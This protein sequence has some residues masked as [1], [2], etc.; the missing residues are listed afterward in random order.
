MG[1]EEEVQTDEKSI[2][3]FSWSFFFKG[4][5]VGGSSKLG[6]NSATG[7]QGVREAFRGLNPLLSELFTPYK[8]LTHFLVLPYNSP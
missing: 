1:A 5:V 3:L 8:K 4:G 2:K 6:M 7:K